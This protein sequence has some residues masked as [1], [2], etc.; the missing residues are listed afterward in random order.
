MSLKQNTVA[1]CLG[2]LYLIIASILVIPFY[3]SYLGPEAYGLV[4]FFTLLQ[5]WLRML[6][7]GMTP[8]LSREAARQ[9][10]GAVSVESFRTLVRSLEYFYLAIAFV[11]SLLMMFASRWIAVSWLKNEAISHEVIWQSLLLMGIIVPLRWLLSLYRGG[12]TGLEKHI[13]LSVFTVISATM[14]TFGVLLV[15]ASISASLVAFFVY[16]AVL[17]IIE[18]VVLVA[19]FRWHLPH[20]SRPPEFSLAALKGVGLFAGSIAVTS[21]LWMVITQTDRLILSNTLLLRDFGFYNLAIAAAVAVGLLSEPVSR[22]IMPRMTALLAQNR[23]QEMIQLYRQATQC[24]VVLTTAMTGTLAGCSE[25]VIYAWTGRLD[26]AEAAGPILLWYALGN[27]ILN[28]LAFQYYLQYSYGR[29]KY[30]L[31]FHIAAVIVWLPAV[32]LVA[33]GYGAIGTGKL[34]F[35]FQLLTFVF[36][37]WYI[38]Q[39]FVPGLHGRWLKEDIIPVVLT[40]TVVLAV[41]KHLLP[42]LD[43]RTRLQCLSLSVAV[44][45]VLAFTAVLSSSF[46]RQQLKVFADRRKTGNAQI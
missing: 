33:K 32:Y 39:K 40:G 8:T 2:S 31:R 28:I 16:Q 22:V 17:A 27:G 15:F 13:W 34:W 3:I 4:G 20:S 21:G 44:F 25:S 7:L 37:T 41:L 38:H 11:V 30:H 14:R 45:V 43:G 1:N 18:T 6:D 26:I 24:V 9:K 36:W 12:L 46:C 19:C 5:Q 10:A 23:E 29:L 35:V 42:A